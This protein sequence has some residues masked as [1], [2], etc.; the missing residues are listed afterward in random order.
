MFGEF[1]GPDWLPKQ[2]HMADLQAE[3]AVANLMDA[4]DGR[5]RRATFKSETDVHSRYAIQRH[6]RGHA[7]HQHRCCHRSSAF[8]GPS[9]SSNGCTCA[10]TARIP[11][12]QEAR[13]LADG[14]QRNLSLSVNRQEGSIAEQQLGR[15]SQRDDDKRGRISRVPWRITRCEPIQA[16]A[17]CARPIG[18]P[19]CHHLSGQ[20]RR[21]ATQYCW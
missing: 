19:T 8:T 1:P 16:P 6:V 15:Y 13:P 18:R 7:N 10:S 11:G 3:A 12:T 4:F 17:I 2:A 5:R 21:S 9:A 20:R 14:G